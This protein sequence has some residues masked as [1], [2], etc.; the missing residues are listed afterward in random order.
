MLE[1]YF[2]NGRKIDAVWQY[3]IAD[4]LEEFRNEF[5]GV[6]FQ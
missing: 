1:S 2:R 3:V 6:V 4:C 5:S